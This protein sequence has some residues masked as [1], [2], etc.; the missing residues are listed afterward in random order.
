MFLHNLQLYSSLI[1]RVFQLKLYNGFPNVTV[2]WVLRKRL[3]LKAY[4]LFVVQYLEGPLKMVVRPKYIA[5]NL[6]KIVNNYWNRVPLD[7]NP[8]TWSNTRNRMQT[9]KLRKNVFVNWAKEVLVTIVEYMYVYAHIYKFLTTIYWRYW[10][11]QMQQN[12]TKY[13]KGS[14]DC[15]QC[16][17]SVGSRILD[18]C[19]NCK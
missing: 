17:E 3:H 8:W 14:D 5:D 9:H 10:I 16:S 15:V 4:K 7:G 1:Y 18:I 6:N 11:K 19:R 2:W 12:N 13:L